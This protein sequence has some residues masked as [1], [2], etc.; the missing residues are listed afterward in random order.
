MI[1]IP[2]ISFEFSLNC[3]YVQYLFEYQLFVYIVYYTKG[4][5]SIECTISFL[6]YLVD[7][8]LSALCVC[9]RMC[10]H[11]NMSV[12]LA[13]GSAITNIHHYQL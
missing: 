3:I 8:M 10:I 13:V 5:L 4:S 2:N 11:T 6:H 12:Y 9:A 1:F 7:A